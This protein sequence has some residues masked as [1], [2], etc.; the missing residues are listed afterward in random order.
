MAGGASRRNA[1]ASVEHSKPKCAPADSEFGV[2]RPLS[3]LLV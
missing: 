3:Q 1:P 2:A